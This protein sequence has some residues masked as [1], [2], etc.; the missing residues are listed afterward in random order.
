MEYPNDGSSGSSPILGWYTAF[1][2]RFATLT[3]AHG[4]RTVSYPDLRPTADNGPDWFYSGIDNGYQ[5]TSGS[6]T[7]GV[8]YLLSAHEQTT[9]GNERFVTFRVNGEIV[10]VVNRWPVNDVTYGVAE[11]MMPYDS[12]GGQMIGVDWTQGSYSWNQ[13][14]YW[15]GAVMLLSDNIPLQLARKMDYYLA[16]KYD[17]TLEDS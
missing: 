13:Y 2:C 4:K 9:K 6:L 17:I 7:T 15:T 12:Y 11:V 5:L 10:G 1:V 16:R 3:G 8:N 14:M